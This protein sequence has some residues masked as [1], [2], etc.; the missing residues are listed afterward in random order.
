MIP[1]KTTPRLA[2]RRELPKRQRRRELRR[3]RPPK[4]KEQ[5]RM[6]QRLLKQIKTQNK[7]PGIGRK[8]SRK[9]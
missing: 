6:L 9:V 5:C 2:K 4:N 7:N 1:I 3:N 8:R